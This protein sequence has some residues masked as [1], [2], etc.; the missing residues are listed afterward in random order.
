MSSKVLIVDDEPNI[1]MSLEFLLKKSGYKVFIARDGREALDIVEKELPDI[2]LLDVMM[3]EVD[4]YE[5]CQKI[6]NDKETAH[7][8]IVFLSAKTKQEDIDKGYELGAD[9]YITKPFSTRNLI[10][11]VDSLKTP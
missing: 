6:K 8:K 3:P 2:I 1:L 5:V 10:T 7:I 9:L 11:K 4:G